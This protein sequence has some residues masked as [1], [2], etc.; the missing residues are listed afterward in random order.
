[1]VEGMTNLLL[2]TKQCPHCFNSIAPEKICGCGIYALRNDV[3]TQIKPT[4]QPVN[5]PTPKIQST[6]EILTERGNRYG[7]FSGHAK[8]T[9]AIKDVIRS[10]VS[11]SQCTPAQIEAL[12][13]IAHKIGRIVNGD[14][15]YDD[16]WKDICG[17]SQLVV[18]ILNGKDT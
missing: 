16:S 6:E 7:K 9:Q 11:Y 13:M 10:G 14:P 3:L 15:H 18:D 8:V 4:A 2:R 17:Y 12:E 1:M 5:K